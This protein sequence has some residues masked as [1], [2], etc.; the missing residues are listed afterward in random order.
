MA[1]PT[2]YTLY[3]E[4]TID[5]TKVSGTSNLSN[6]PVYI[7]LSDLS[8]QF[9]NNVS[10]GGGDI[11]VTLDDGTTQLAR[12]VVSC[13]T[14][15]D[16]GELHVNVSTLDY[17]DDTVIRVWYNGTDTEPAADSTYGSEATW[18]G[19]GY[20]Q[21]A[22]FDDFNDS[23]E[24]SN[25]LTNNGTTDVSGKIGR[26]RS[27]DGNNDYI[28]TGIKPLFDQDTTIQIWVNLD[29]GTSQGNGTLFNERTGNIYFA[30]SPPDGTDLNATIRDSGDNTIKATPLVSSGWFLYHFV[31]DSSEKKLSVYKDGSLSDSDT[32]SS[33]NG[34]L[35]S[36]MD[37]F[38]ILGHPQ[39]YSGDSAEYLKAD[40]D[41]YRA[42]IGTAM[43]S[44]WISTEYNNQNSPST[45]YSVVAKSDISTQSITKSLQYAIQTSSSITKS[46][47]Y[48][49]ESPQSITKSLKYSVIT[50]TPITKQLKYSVESEQSITKSLQYS[51]KLSKSITKT[52][53]YKVLVTVS[54]QVTLAG[55]GQSG[56]KVTIINSSDDTIYDTDTTDGDGNY[57]FIVPSENTWHL[58][59]EYD[60]GSQKYNS[61][62]KPY[63]ST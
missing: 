13:D 9:W 36:S 18:S 20:N 61:T 27:G 10:N 4:V 2:G 16:T 26:G 42:I 8:T 45:F 53:S 57:S 29:G 43:S 24:N 31:F 12:E 1:F 14:S 35:S 40:V 62:S 37:S 6:F 63:I 49:V 44:D 58:T 3:D 41:E 56:A 22:H 32:N 48:S 39:N 19:V 5:N 50:T 47:Q 7:D 25:T 23:T 21:V 33:Y 34:S 59:V 60:S 15:T 46:L 30:T 38:D 52:L 55:V 17:N 28:R 54:G 11:R 51:V